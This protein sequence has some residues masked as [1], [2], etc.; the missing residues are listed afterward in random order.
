MALMTTITPADVAVALGREAPQSG[1]ATESQ[2]AMWATDALMLIQSRVDELS[3]DETAIDQARL[4]YVVREAV[5][6]QVRRPDDATQVTKAVDD[7]SVTKIYK[8]ARGRVDILDEW[9]ALL[10]VV[11]SGG[12]AFAVDVMTLTAV[13]QPWCNVNLGANY[14][15]CGADLTGGD[16]LWEA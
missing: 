7:G 1:S 4:D 3:H 12:Q 14:C 6:A 16:P 8:S 5:V 2:W 15:S 13:H 11:A 10:G 9:W